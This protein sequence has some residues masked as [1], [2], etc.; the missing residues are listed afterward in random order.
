MGSEVSEKD[1]DDG[2]DGGPKPSGPGKPPGP[3]TK[4]SGSEIIQL[5][6]SAVAAIAAV[7]VPSF[8]S[9]YLVRGFLHQCPECIASPEQVCAD[10]TQERGTFLRANTSYSIMPFVDKN[11]TLQL[12]GVAGPD[13]GPFDPAFTINDNSGKRKETS[14]KVDD[15][16]KFLTEKGGTFQSRIVFARNSPDE[17]VCISEPSQIAD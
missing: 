12:I 15:F 14:A 7:A 13:K 8:T 4:L 2:A 10:L 1:V 9:G 11:V 5:V 17:V 3:L 16:L 6:I